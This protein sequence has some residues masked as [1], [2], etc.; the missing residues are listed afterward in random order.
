MTERSL[1]EEG[2]SISNAGIVLLNAYFPM[3]F[4][5]LGLV[6]NHQFATETAQK[7]AVH[8][9]QYVATGLS[10]TEESHLILNKVLCGMEVTTSV[11]DSL[12]ISEDNKELIQ[13]MLQSAI[14]YWSAIG[15]TSIEGF[16]GNWLVREGILTES[17]ERW[18]LSVEKRP[19]DILLMKSPF[20]FSIIKFP[21][22]EKPLYVTWN[23]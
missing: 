8:Y 11:P 10:N 18:E 21:W 15:R 9:L 1:P 22:M 17:E 16:R 12:E 5:R 20:S 7:E 13:G 3:L 23:Y 19:Y 6:L 4:E 14:A 2:V